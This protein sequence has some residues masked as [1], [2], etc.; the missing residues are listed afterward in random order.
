MTSLNRVVIGNNGFGKSA[1]ILQDQ[2]SYQEVPDLYWRSTIWAT[3][4]CPVDNTVP[5]DRAAGVVKTAF[6]LKFYD[7]PAGAAGINR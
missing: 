6:V 2:P 4:E 1:V 3:S 7:V 5:G